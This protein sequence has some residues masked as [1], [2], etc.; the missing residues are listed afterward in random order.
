MRGDDKAK[1]LE[2]QSLSKTYPQTKD[3]FAD[4]S[5]KI[6]IASGTGK[7]ANSPIKD[8]KLPRYACYLIAHNGRLRE[9]PGEKKLARLN[10]FFYS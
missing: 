7:E 6:K 2:P 4:V 5:K 9:W 8:Y 3:H 1:T 10:S